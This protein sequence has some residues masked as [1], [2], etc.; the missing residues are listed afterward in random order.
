MGRGRRD[1]HAARRER[2]QLDLAQGGPARR[3]SAARRHDRAAPPPGSP[4]ARP[5]SS[6]PIP[7][8]PSLW[9]GIRGPL[10]VSSSLHAGLIVALVALTMLGF[11]KVEAVGD[12][13]EPEKLRLVYLAIPGP[14][15]GGGGGGLKLRTKPPKAERKGNSATRQSAASTV[16]TTRAGSRL[17]RRPSRCPNPNR[18]RPCRR[19]SW[20]SLPTSAIRRVCPSHRRKSPTV[21]VPE[22]MAAS[23]RDKA[24]VLAAATGRESA[25]DKAV[26][27][28]AGRTARAAASR[29]PDCCA[30]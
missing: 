2:A 9:R 26:A 16:A 18:Y 22:A 30:K 14:G 23:A 21:A 20:R 1:P 10:A 4:S 29:R 12:A 19:P 28:V 27:P 5:S 15:G 25:R 3:S 6:I 17:L 8:R 24:L 11:S 13:V 7:R